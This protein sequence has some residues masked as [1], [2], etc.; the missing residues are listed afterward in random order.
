MSLT[1]LAQNMMAS[2]TANTLL[3][4]DAN[5]LATS[6]SP[7]NA[8]V[9]SSGV[10]YGLEVQT[11][12]TVQAAYGDSNYGTPWIN[13]STSALTC[14]IAT[15][16]GASPAIIG[17]AAGFGVPYGAKDYVGY[18]ANDVPTAWSATSSSMT[19]NSTYSVASP[20][21]ISA[22]TYSGS[23][24]TV[25][26][27]TAHSLS[28]GALVTIAGALPTSYNGT[29]GINVTSANTFTYL[30]ASTPAS[31][32]SLQGAYTISTQPSIAFTSLTYSGTTALATTALP[33][34]LTTGQSITVVNTI[35]T[36]YSG[37]YTVTVT[38]SNTFT[39]TMGATPTGNATSLGSYSVVLSPVGISTVTYSGSI[40]TITTTS[41][42]GL[43][44]GTILNISGIYPTTY[45][46]LFTITVSSPTTFSYSMTANPGQ[47]GSL[48]GYYSAYNIAGTPYT[49]VPST[50]ISSI[51]Y[52]GTIATLT[53]TST[54]GLVSGAIVT[55]SGATATNYTGTYVI[56][57]TGASTFTYNMLAA[58]AANATVVGTYTV[59]NFL[60]VDRNANNGGLTF[61]ST[62]LP[63]NYIPGGTN[64]TTL[65]QHT[66]NIQSMTMY[67]GNG[68][69]AT[70]VQR[71]FVGEVNTSI[72]G[73]SSVVVYALQGS[74]DSGYFAVAA[75]T[76]YLKN[77][78]IGSFVGPL[79]VTWSPDTTGTWETLVS[80]SYS[81]TAGW[82]PITLLNASNTTYYQAR[83]ASYITT[84]ASVNPSGNTTGYYRIRIKRSF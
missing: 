33:H 39:Y 4:Y 25:T 10:L 55:I 40:A 62:I 82:Y 78:N 20:V 66:F 19:T 42:H 48:V 59:T 58:P 5:G 13:G 30:M 6:I 54:H 72:S 68:S 67:I 79:Q 37:T 28:T 77:H 9:Q 12:Q 47:V 43:I 57:V 71:V 70:S 83:L 29:Y 38:T 52:S 50:N 31:N 74:Y 56:T 34:G 75:S 1:L 81:T 64:S 22:I 27:S 49:M 23:T 15:G 11:R 46:G 60:F 32:A 80:G 63:P 24:A 76:T 84:L 26:T 73:V 65:A 21:L 3:G 7:A 35:P 61:G 41:T 36:T 51:T 53:T 18:V 69:T 45:N 2:S 44:S 8:L 16:A 14:S 17:F